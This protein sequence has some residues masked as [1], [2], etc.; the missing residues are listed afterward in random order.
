[1]GAVEAL[2]AIPPEPLDPAV[3]DPAVADPDRPP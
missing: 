2:V 3:A 1:M